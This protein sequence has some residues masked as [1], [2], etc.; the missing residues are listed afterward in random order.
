MD[1][2]AAKYVA[3][4]DAFG[5]LEK[6]IDYFSRQ[7]ILERTALP[8]PVVKPDGPLAPQEHQSLLA[9][10]RRIEGELSFNRLSDQVN[11]ST[12]EQLIDRWA[13][14]AARDGHFRLAALVTDVAESR[15][16]LLKVKAET[17]LEVLSVP[18]YAAHQEHIDVLDGE[19]AD[20]RSAFHTLEKGNPDTR[21][22][23]HKAVKTYRGV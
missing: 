4:T 2:V 19:Y 15:S 20:L 3:A 23:M 5:Q 10:M 21:A 8:V 12:D 22:Q 18:E 1:K 13:K 14:Q 11:R 7:S 17:A 16:G 6:D 9:S